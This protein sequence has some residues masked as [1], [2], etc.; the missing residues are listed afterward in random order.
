MNDVH[1]LDITTWAW[2]Q[3]DSI[4]TPPA[5]RYWH[6][7]VATEGRAFVFGG[8]NATQ[9]FDKLFMISSDW[10][11]CS[12]LCC[13]HANVAVSC[14]DHVIAAAHFLHCLVM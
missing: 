4:G 3:M 7:C 6:S 9:T 10:S 1:V 8:S 12:H 13:L 5:P 14:L 2:Y 11:R